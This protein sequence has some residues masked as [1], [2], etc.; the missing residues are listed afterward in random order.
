MVINHGEMI[1]EDGTSVITNV[2]TDC[3]KLIS[4]SAAMDRHGSLR[5]CMKLK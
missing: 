2:L 1:I 5:D 4:P 3:T